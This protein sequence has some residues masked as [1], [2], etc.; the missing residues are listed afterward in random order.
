MIRAE[1]LQAALKARATKR[2]ATRHRL[3]SE[4]LHGLTFSAAF[5][6]GNLASV[7]ARSADE[8][9]LHVRADAEGTQYATRSRTWFCFSIRGAATGRTL[10]LEVRMSNQAKL[11]GHDHRPCY[12]SLPSRP[13]WERLPTATPCI[14]DGATTDSFAIQITHTVD[15]PSTDTLFFGFCFPHGYVEQMATLA[16]ADALFRQ[17]TAKLAPAAPEA[18]TSWARAVEF[19]EATAEAA[20]KAEAAASAPSA[21]ESSRASSSPGAPPPVSADQMRAFRAKRLAQAARAAALQASVSLEEHEQPADAAAA[22]SA[23]HHHV[24][25]AD[26]AAQH[27]AALLPSEKVDAGSGGPSSIYYRREL[28]T[29]SLEGR[30]IDLITVTSSDGQLS[31]LEPPLPAPLL[32]E[33]PRGALGGDGG[34]PTRPCRFKQKK[35]VLV[36]GRVH[37]GETPAS[38]VIDGLLAFL[39]RPDDPRAVAL[40]AR[41][42]FKII[43]MLNP[44]GVYHGHYRADTRGVDLNRKYNARGAGTSGGASAT[45]S[46]EE[47]A[48]A[49]FPSV[50][51]CLEVARQLHATG[52]SNL[53]AYMDT[54]AHAGRR[55]CFFY[56]NQMPA[57]IA[58]DDSALFARLV[59]LNTRWFDFDGC[60]WFEPEAH[61]GSARSAVFAATGLPHVFT[62]E[63]NYDSGIAA[64]DLP[65]RHTGGAASGRLSP[66]PPTERALSPKYTDESW[67]D[68]GKALAL[69]VLD[70]ANCNPC[71]RL[72]P[73]GGDGLAKLRGQVVAAQQQKAA[74]RAERSK[75]RAAKGGLRLGTRE[76][77]GEDDDDEEDDEDDEAEEDVDGAREQELAVVGAPPPPPIGEGAPPPPPIAGSTSGGRPP[78]PP[79]PPPPPPPKPT[80]SKK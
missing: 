61:A 74:R 31:A 39:L 29:H 22:A 24:A 52:D 60:T 34:G 38:H 26:A 56:G 71:S 27:A 53:L 15:T 47:D 8:F 57:P 77:W 30:R 49:L 28:L 1:F 11:F 23:A 37:P 51:A 9:T 76:R 67:R 72:G 42:V 78:P 5:D 20:E 46:G 54:H 40:R 48:H 55:G 66:E 21:T 70:M 45:I 12:R 25:I 7:E 73:P 80:K 65:P 58:R 75:A 17:P 4:T 16:W 35:Y 68:L 44:D 59:A 2:P 41:F 62:L 6:G 3:Q 63:C 14:V 79:A 36:S 69:A 13:R 18:A 33:R 64:N 50:T 43:P 32:P 19:V 10:H